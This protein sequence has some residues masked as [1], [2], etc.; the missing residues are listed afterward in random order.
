M[1]RGGRNQLISVSEGNGSEGFSKQL[2]QSVSV[3]SPPLL[4]HSNG[5]FGS[6]LLAGLAATQGLQE[7]S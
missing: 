5:S 1:A 4:G 6:L 2:I 3:A 7:K